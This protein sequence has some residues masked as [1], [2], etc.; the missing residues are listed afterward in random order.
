[1]AL[2]KKGNLVD[3]IA[4]NNGIYSKDGTVMLMANDNTRYINSQAFMDAWNGVKAKA[5]AKKKKTSAIKEAVEQVKAVTPKPEIRGTRKAT[6]EK[7]KK[8]KW[9][10]RK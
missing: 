7:S 4:T 9:F 2:S 1:M 6:A 3:S 10:G 5:P 8:K